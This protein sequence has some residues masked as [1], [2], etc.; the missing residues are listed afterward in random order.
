MLHDTQQNISCE[1]RELCDLDKDLTHTEPLLAFLPAVSCGLL[2]R[3]WQVPAKGAILLWAKEPWVIKSFLLRP[4]SPLLFSVLSCLAEAASP[5]QALVF[6]V[7]PIG[8]SP[9]ST[10]RNVFTTDPS[11]VTI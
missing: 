10:L 8:I 11:V 3:S 2:R 1:A 7:L 6:C 4:C 5:R 9:H